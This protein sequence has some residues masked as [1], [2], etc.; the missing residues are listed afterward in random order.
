MTTLAGRTI[1]ALRSEHDT[2]ASTVPALTTAQLTG[3]SGA[4]EWTVADVLSHLGSGAEITLADFRASLGEA[5]PP[6]PG[7]NQSVW[8]RWNALSPQD[9]AAGSLGS[10]AAL[11]TALEAVPEERHDEL[12]VKPGFLPEPLPLASFAAMRLSEVVQHGWDVRVGTDPA[13]ALAEPAAL[14]LAEHFSGGLGFL[15]GFIAKPEAVREHAVIEISG[16]PYRIVVDDRI[17]LTAEALPATATFAGPVESAVRLLAGRLTPKHTPPG[18]EVTG[19]V[20]LD[21]L[22]AV[23]P[24]F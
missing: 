5:E 12:K 1:A 17:R 19:N 4:A 2:L 6:A 13:A 24:G 3:P 23:F 15:L 20:S 8:D 18:V 10:D 7:F 21:E 14:L 16:T 9:Q 11:V 22:R